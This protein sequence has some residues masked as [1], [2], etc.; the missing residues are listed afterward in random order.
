MVVRALDVVDVRLQAVQLVV[1]GESVRE[2]AAQFSTSKTQLYEW[3]KA[4]QRDGLE[5]LLP[6]SRRPHSSPWQVDSEVE[7][8][9][10]R[11]RK[12]R[13]RWGAKKIHAVLIRSGWPAPARSTVHEVL[14]RR[15]LVAVQPTRRT[16]PGG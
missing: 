4:Y 3:V 14:R 5:G 7:D 16:P 13:P 15:G 12:A 2:V 8:E 9:I 10:V 11:I 1:G 6:K